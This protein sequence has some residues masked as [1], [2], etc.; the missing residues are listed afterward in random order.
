MVLAVV[1]RS[2][3]LQPAVILINGSKTQIDGNLS[4]G[5]SVVEQQLINARSQVQFLLGRYKL[6]KLGVDYRETVG[7]L[8]LAD[9]VSEGLFSLPIVR[10]H[11]DIETPLISAMGALYVKSGCERSAFITTV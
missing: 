5:S 9:I 8:S 7:Y 3:C 11:D 2:G 1:V 6:G 4:L 10:L